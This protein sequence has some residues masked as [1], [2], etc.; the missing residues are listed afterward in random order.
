MKAE[1][2]IVQQLTYGCDDG[3][4]VHHKRDPDLPGV[5]RQ[6]TI[7]CITLQHVITIESQ[8]PLEKVVVASIF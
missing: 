3:N 2:S 5:G 6:P 7:D 8:P 4:D 1:C